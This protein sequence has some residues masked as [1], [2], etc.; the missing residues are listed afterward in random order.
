MDRFSG[1]VRASSFPILMAMP[2]DTKDSAQLISPQ[3]VCS[4][5]LGHRWSQCVGLGANDPSLDLSLRIGEWT[6]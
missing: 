6:M 1:P 3:C 4:L 2:D 5:L